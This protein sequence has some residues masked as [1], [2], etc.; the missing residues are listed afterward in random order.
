M[1]SSLERTLELMPP[2]N[3]FG[4]AVEYGAVCIGR[5]GDIRLRGKAGHG[6]RCSKWAGWLHARED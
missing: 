2:D 1:K 4:A 5:Y 6:V 3:Q